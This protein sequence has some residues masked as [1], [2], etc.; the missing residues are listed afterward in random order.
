[1]KKSYI[2]LI[3]LFAYKFI[4][5]EWR[6]ILISYIFYWIQIYFERMKIYF[7]ITYHLW[8]WQPSLVFRK[9]TDVTPYSFKK[10]ITENQVL[11]VINEVEKNN[12]GIKSSLLLQIK[13]AK[14]NDSITVQA[15]ISEEIQLRIDWRV[16]DTCWSTR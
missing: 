4:F 1:M 7:G 2:I 8:P 12:Y 5:I 6:Y 3:F 9:I 13:R 15:E 10:K 11:F 16:T 14:T